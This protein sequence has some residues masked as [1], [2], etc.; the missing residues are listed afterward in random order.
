MR[1]K[2]FKSVLI[3]SGLAASVL[4]LASGAA[5]GQAVTAAA[6]PTID[7]GA[8]VTTAALTLT[9]PIDTG[10]SFNVIPAS[11][12]SVVDANGCAAAGVAATPCTMNVTF[13]PTTTGAFTANF[14]LNGTSTVGTT[15]TPV[16]LAASLTGS[17]VSG[18][19]VTATASGNVDV[20]ASLTTLALTLTT[21]SSTTVDANSISVTGLNPPF[22]VTDP[23][24]CV[25]N[26]LAAGA[27][28][29][30]NVTFA[31]TSQGP[32]SDTVTVTA[33][34]NAGADSLGN[35]TANLTGNG[36][37]PTVTP[38]SP[39]V[40][41]DLGPGVP[42]P[43]TVTVTLS[44]PAETASFT[45]TAPLTGSTA[46]T[47]TG[48]TCGVTP[49]P[50]AI[51]LGGTNPTS[52]TINVAYTPST[53]VDTSP[54]ATLTVNYAFGT[55]ATTQL[56]AQLS[57]G[58]INPT[59]GTVAAGG[60]TT[61]EVELNA[62]ATT[63]TLPDGS[64]VPMWGYQ[65]GAN[66][67]AC[68][69]LNPAVPPRGAASGAWS[70]V[71][72]TALTG[73]NLAID[74]TNSLSFAGGT[75]TVP[76]S[77]VIV[78]QVGGGL[79]TVRTTTPSPAHGTQSVTWPTANSGPTNLPPPQ[80]PRV[81]SF[82]T[83]AAAGTTTRLVWN[84]LRAGT[85]LIESGTHPSI[86]GP[87][88]L[89]GILVVTTA[90]T[91][92]AG[93]ETAPGCAYPGAAAGSCAIPYD[94]EV[95]MLFSEIDPVQNTTV[96][97]AV[98]TA[99]FS[100][101]AVWSGQ[102]G[103]CGNPAS[104]VGVI[105]TCYPPAVN[106]TPLYY[107]INGVAFSKTSAAGSLFPITPATIAPA[108]GTTGNVLVRLVN[109]GLRMHVPAIV[110][111]QVAGAT[112]GTNPVVTGFKVMAEDG[113]PLPGVPK[114]KSEVFM[115]AGK[116]YD[117]MI[118]GQSTSGT[119]ITPY[120]FALPIYDRELSLSGNA[121]E[122]DAGMLA[123]IGING[124][125]LPVTS[126]T[127]PLAA[128]VARAD[129]YNALVAGQPL[130][131]SDPSKG[132]IANDTNVYGVKVAATLCSGSTPPTTPTSSCSPAGGTLSLNANGTFTYVPNTGTTSDWFVYQAN[133]N[134]PFATVTLGASN[135]VDAAGVTCTA[136]AF[137]ASMATYYAAKTPGVLAH[138]TDGA[139]LP[140]TVVPASVVA[141]G[142]TVI[143]DANGGFTAIAPA[144]G[145]YTFSVTVQNSH[146]VTGT[147]SAT[148]TF[149]AGSGLTVNVVDGY[150]KVTP[151]T[152]YRWIIEEDRTF[153]INPACTPN[154]PPAG[155]PTVGLGIVP[156]FGTNFHTSYM[157]Y[158]AQGCTGPQSCEGGQ[159]VFDPSTG[160]H[161]A[162][163]CDVGNG[164]C[165]PDTSGSNAGATAVSPGA[166][167]L[168]PTKRYYISILP[169]DAANP[170]AAGYTGPNCQYG[171]AQAPTGATC[172]H[173]MGGAPIAAGQT[174][175]TVL[176]QPSPYPP[177]KLSV[178]VFED[179]FPLNGEQDGGG[180]VDVLSPVEPGLGGFQ[181]HLWDAMGGNGD[182][183]GQMGFDMFNQPLTN[184]LAGTKDPNNGNDACPIGKNELSATTGANTTTLSTDPLAT[185]ITGFIVTCPKY[186]S[187]G[188]SLSPLAGQAVIANLMPGRWGVIATPGADRI[189]RGEEW[190]QTNTLDGQKAHDV[191]TRIGEPSYFQEFGPASYH[192][193]IG[194]AN[195]AIINARH[196]YVCSGTDPNFPGGVG[197]CNNTIT[198]KVTGEHLSRTPDER[199]Y[200][201]GSHD[202]YY[203]S[204]C[205]VSFGD[206][207]GEDFAFTKCNGDGTFTLTGLPAGN[208]RVTV[209]DQWNDLLVDGLSTPVG[210]TGGGQTINMGDIASTQWEANLYTRTFIDD[211]QDGISQASEN[212]IPFANVAVRLRDG[213]LENLLV[214]D[215]TGTANFNE[216][217]PL[218][219][220]YVVETDVTR[221][222]NTGTHVVYDVGG[223]VDGSA[224]CGTTGYPPCGTSTIGHLLASTAEIVSVPMNL[225]VPGSVY[226]ANADCTGKTIQVPAVSD[227]PSV[228]STNTTATPPTT[229]CSTQLSSGRIDPPWVGTEG[230]QGFPGQNNFME[231]GKEPYVP[232]ENGGI[233]G[234]VIYAST[235]PF[236]D[237]QQLV[238]TQWVPLVPHVTMNLY[239][240][241]FA[242]D[243]ITP[244]LTLVDTTQTSSWDDYAQGFRADGVTPNMN[245]PG[246][247]ASSG[248]IPDL[249]YF[250]L[251]NQPNYLNYYNSVHGGGA[252]TALPD[253]S[254][255]KCYDGMH[256]WNQIQPAP[257][258][259]MYK[260]P[261]V[262][263]VDANGKPTGTNCKICSP[264]PVPAPDLYAGIPM[265]PPGKYV[266]EVVLPPGYELVK[267]E[268]KN[269]LIGDNFIAPVTQEFGGLSN[270]FIIPDQASV[271]ASQQYPG[272]GYNA[273]NAQNPT[274]SFGTS[275]QNG[276]VPSFVPEPTWP[277]VGEARI[278]PD[279]ISLF[280]QSHQVA[281][282][283]G[284]TRHLCD[285]KEVTLGDEMGAIAKFYVYTSTH[286]ASKFTG[287]ITDDYTSEFDPFSPQFGEKFAPPNLPI[288]VK[289]W[290]GN[291]TSRVYADH[292][293]A[294]NG[295]TYST[296]EVNPP[297]PTGY[298]PTMMVFCMNDPG[299]IPGPG[300][301][302][303]QDPL[304]TPGYSQFCYELPFMPGTTQYLDTPVVPTSAF[305]GAGYNNVDCA[306]PAATP[307]I[308]EV[309]GDGIGPWVSAPLHTLTITA[310]GDQVVPNY[311][312][313]GPASTTA[314]FNQKTITRHYG[315]G[316]TQGTG[317]VTIGGINAPVTGTG[318]SD[319][320][321]QVTVP[322]GVANCA[323]QQQAQYVPSG[324]TSTQCGQL[325]ITAGNGKQSIDT[326]NV[327][328]GGNT[329]THV[330][331]S[332]SIQSA[333]DAAAPGDLIIIDPTCSTA[334]TS[335][336]PC[337]TA[338]VTAKTTAAH[339]ELL[340]MW[341]PVR[342]Q[343]VGAASS[344]INANTQPAGKLDPWRQKVNC[345]FGLNLQGTPLNGNL[346]SFDPSGAT[347]CPWNT[348]TVNYF[349]YTVNNPQVDPLPLEAIVGWN[350]SQNGNLA[351]L[352][353]EPSLMGALEG[354]GITVLGKGVNFPSPLTVNTGV[355]G[356]L[357]G[358]P[359]GTTLLTGPVPVA[360]GAYVTGDANPLCHTS[361]SVTT[362]PFPSSFT[363]NPSSIDGLTITD[364]SQGGGGIFA[365]GWAHNLQI[366]NNRIYSNAGTLSGGI[367]VGQG[368]FAPSNIQGSATNAPPGSCVTSGVVTNAE[369]P[370]CNNLNVNVH[371]NN[372]SLNSSTGDELF[373]GTPA[374]AG[375]VSICTGADYYKFNYNWVCGNLSS[376]DGGGMA[377]MGFSYNGDIEH[378]TI[379][380]NQSLNPTIPANGG[381]LLVMGTPDVDTTCGGAIDIDCLDPASLRTPSDGAGP[382]LVINAN[383][384]M[385]NGAEA[386]SGGGL[387]L[388]NVNGGDVL[389]FPTTPSRWYSPTVTNNIIA[390]NVAGWDGAGI[391]MV[392][393]LNV[394]IINNT[395]VS[396]STTA[397][398][399]ILFTTIGYPLA[400]SEG[401]NCTTSPTTS[402][403]QVAGL[404]TI[405]NSA[406][407]QANLPA[408]VTCPPNHYAG[409]TASNGT[410]R[411]VSYPLLQNNIFWQNSAYYI[412]VGALS[413]QYQQN[414][415]SLY[416]AFTTTLAPTQP[417]AD[418]TTANGAGRTIT[419][420]TGACVAANYWDIG[421]RGDRTP[422]THESGVTLAPTYSV[423]T[424]TTTGG[425]N[426]A[427]LH[428]S[429][430]NPNFLSQYCDGARTPPEFGASGWAVPPGIADATVPNPIFNLTP[431]A[432]VDEGNNWINLRWGPLT[433]SNPVTNN[434][435]GNYALTAGSAVIDAIPTSEPNYSLVPRTDFFGNLRPEPTPAGD[436]H[437]DPGAAEFG[438]VPPVATLS[439]T[440]GPL[441]FLNAGVGFPT[442]AKTLT[443][444]NTGTA[445]GAGITL[446][447]SSTVFSRAGGNCGT[448]LAAGANCTITVVFTPT[449]T[450]TVTSTLTISAN[451]GVAG[452]PVALSGTGA[453]D[454][455]SA[456][457]KPAT[458]NIYHAANCPGTGVGT[459]A[460]LLDPT[461]AF[462]LTNTG[463]VPLTGITQGVLGGT[464]ANV[465]N[466]LR[467]AL[468]S[469]CGPAGGGQLMANTTLAPGG[470]CTIVVQF[471]PLT[472]QA[473]GAKPAT[474]SV[475]DL[476][477]TQT[478]ILNGTDALATVNIAAPTP[479]LVTGATTTHTGIVTVSNAAA[480]ASPLILTANP[481]IARVGTAGGTFSIISGGT[482][483]S[484]AVVNAGSNCTINVQYAPGGSAVTATA[485]VTITGNATAG[486]TQTSV[487]FTAN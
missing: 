483:I 277:C 45:F 77:I 254:Q 245:C 362:N 103:G 38:A 151:I 1:S 406:G 168:D 248:P 334:T 336:V 128:A 194:F 5:F 233:K 331:A 267:E 482:C 279:Y 176:T 422:G 91:A 198:G 317:S 130:T 307:A 79:G 72:I 323:V 309:D 440:G 270:I 201:T 32:A 280:P 262:T 173:G 416:N 472:A 431:V 269:I 228:C 351:Q 480:A 369:L 252:L 81:Q 226:C 183:T 463:N 453:A 75:N 447:F 255:F 253:N 8:S 192:V 342:L 341:K 16:A 197:A 346:G 107:T 134:G 474:I 320:S 191:F 385:G 63:V 286:I 112:G 119:S 57:L 432:T 466:W 486:G 412:G 312:Y 428:N 383:L 429:A 444:H 88:G 475:T 164:L 174:A 121:V 365:H 98:G 90:P 46:F 462:T 372:I 106:Y 132:V 413:A 180:G 296:W 136:S 287:G 305:A 221:Y 273:N 411:T 4:L 246:Q 313:S 401:I 150:D 388:Q 39:V 380:F 3:K 92:P 407:L 240:E 37:V 470:T 189:A 30:M 25:A 59:G 43:K 74:L 456:T 451:V 161:I 404:V 209:F 199:L 392:D 11:P 420:G 315:F 477:G 234:H 60:G 162:A 80:G 137:N 73:Q 139:K 40:F 99:G 408:T 344:I 426:A 17:G 389:A 410:C 6:S 443:L 436:S 471:R 125:G 458:W 169:G 14:T 327:T 33:T 19:T 214:T 478:S 345:L 7:V 328:I 131:V 402:C 181:I 42:S 374:G 97:Q 359:T 207:D 205:Y 449:A 387:R 454:V 350:A 156:T 371:H 397:S 200:S 281:P 409:T 44:N 231:F 295:M 210:I 147:A 95:P 171:S 175:V 427:A 333:I 249:F 373:S 257:Y 324:T 298:S 239:Q 338:G 290:A 358:F 89:Y 27:T 203:W 179:D 441:T 143:P 316:A 138:C 219:S 144:A 167:A 326:I 12:F 390:D 31:P 424:S 400:S 110:G 311:A 23:N 448:T 177:G 82:A 250:S 237:P 206:P 261:S 41:N 445:A 67:L 425:Y 49:T 222:K 485:N 381:G 439:V 391:S 394:N 415:I 101:T 118:N 398:A 363:C 100:E 22:S 140:L 65:C 223:P 142:M 165:R 465:A 227:P 332:G 459:F 243:G 297:N 291:E 259:G 185:G 83:E 355:A 135:I 460:C 339:N 452:S 464:A 379:L 146:G 111:S 321:I 35:L 343:G 187:D 417:Q 195:P 232:G 361:S 36:T 230:W 211:N 160:T 293:G 244:T 87:M 266:V 212:G 129:T 469:S 70:P 2:T 258:D 50:I 120:A 163:V 108:T 114:I 170:F 446:A 285:R 113:R 133:G 29:K 274:Q 166:V 220:W 272:P 322:P 455:I 225:R 149:P 238:Q 382:N 213:S 301:T 96:S 117:V 115:A 216:T 370:Y 196:N 202:T 247:G 367:I 235:R 354:A 353:Q 347:S 193:S 242:S 152:D 145:T 265:L 284:A 476:A 378:N 251:Y 335:G 263:A 93:V 53:G 172:G 157:P 21:D 319:N 218:F 282:F 450:G 55:A 461:Q 18:L 377:H 368:E 289:D 376:G 155:C 15:V 438:S 48:G 302:M 76:T 275:E 395:I 58:E 292:W 264:D 357:G 66:S 78:G 481:T 182:F 403:P 366:A 288:S 375:G 85:Y 26:G 126:G 396:N 71:V 419:G 190:L 442:A 457:L 159:T 304:Y 154:P 299:P 364:S 20:G 384:I 314:P 484:G 434:Q 487:N 186:E 127:G 467:V 62:V 468:L 278:V 10:F 141:T 356:E 386:G 51:T 308:A 148:V 104:P 473:A 405:Q 28:C 435:L 303:I 9:G 68:A 94:A 241:G 329:P 188:V 86:Q 47:V 271:S 423:L 61:V 433:L 34:T 418:A 479:S 260:F 102:P 105:N 414:V 306:Y 24:S 13:S 310:L 300:G 208:W 348:D 430:S 178:F 360:N 54:S 122:R 352:L 56:V 276:I 215:F 229:T 109:A 124:N 69:A 217:F 116:V 158:V 318:W 294:Y 153:Y 340:L 268:D 393:A 52:C 399:G 349:S 64:I 224:A 256:N 325:V 283:A 236:D 421:V 84:N 330:A 123:Y 437:F 204:Q 184:S 337:A